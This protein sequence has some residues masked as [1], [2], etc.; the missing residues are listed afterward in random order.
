MHYFRLIV[1]LFIGGISIDRVDGQSISS[2]D[3]LKT[4]STTKTEPYEKAQVY[5]QIAIAYGFEK[6]ET[7][8]VYA[9]KSLELLPK[10]SLEVRGNMYNLIGCL[11]ANINVDS[12][13]RAF[14]HFNTA[15]NCFK[16]H[17]DSTL[18]AMV[19]NNMANYYCLIKDYEKG[20]EYTYK[21]LR[22]DEAANY[23]KGIA[24]H[25]TTITLINTKQ[26]D[27]KE[28]LKN[29]K[30]SLSLSQK[31]GD[32]NY[33]A[34]A[35]FNV[36]LVYSKLEFLDSSIYYL[37]IA[38]KN[39]QK[40]NYQTHI[41]RAYAEL[42]SVY[43]KKKDLP[44]ALWCIRKA[45][46]KQ[47]YFFS[48]SE[49]LANQQVLAGIYFENGDYNK[50][51]ALY[52]KIRKIAQ[53]KQSTTAL[54][55]A[56]YGLSETYA[57]VNNQGEAYH[58]LLRYAKLKDSLTK[59]KEVEQIKDL[60][61]KYQIAYKTQKKEQEN[62]LLGK[63][64]AIQ[65]LIL[66]KN[67][68]W[69]YGIFILIIF[70]LLLAYL[71]V[72]QY[73]LKTS[74]Q[75]LQLKHQLL[76][77]QMN[78]HFIFNALTNIQKFVYQN[79]PIQAGKYLSSFS[80]LIRGILENSREEYISLKK[81]KEWLENYL[82][83]QIL[84]F[85]DR[86]EYQIKIDPTLNLSTCLIPPMLIQPFIENALEHG[87]KGIKHWGIL[88]VD[89]TKLD[90]CLQISIKDNG[91]GFSEEHHTEQHRNRRSLAI[92]ITKERLDFINQKRNSKI[93]FNIDSVLSKGTL[94]TFSI[95]LKNMKE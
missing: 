46:K 84:R 17:Q 80:R 30:R 70:A 24:A 43:K 93:Y 64:L 83:L 71:L 26:K 61:I 63:N 86:F 13:P 16:E 5:Y 42:A 2:I 69:F 23:Q 59:I 53:G 54:L 36:G 25:L 8:I 4:I 11:S 32:F 6:S 76:R 35:T 19:Y 15:L 29:A 38:L 55:N 52:K 75:M 12:L 27:Y 31:I 66:H 9:K 14:I 21:A 20:L 74:Q 68:Q 40:R 44:S 81:E 56:N 45:I 88:N 77:N 87:L 79:A 65:E 91:L 58:H 82:N 62:K 49:R 22:I 95:P 72:R 33:V 41:A 7:A 47:E 73:K 28:A 18:I 1:L 57:A 48:E 78:P 60:K 37:S 89:F 39:A 51:I 94:V 10:D 67:K 3:S 34:D 50:S 92:K 90:T 85:K